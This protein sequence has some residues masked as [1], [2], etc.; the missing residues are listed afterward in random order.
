AS[1][2]A[3]TATIFISR[4]SPKSSRCR[5]AHARK[6]C[7]R[8]CSAMRRGSSTTFAKI[9]TTG[10][11]GMTSGISK[12]VA[13]LLLTSALCPSPS[14]AAP[15]PGVDAATLVV[16]LKRAAPARTAYT[17]V[18]FSG[19]LD[20]PLILRGTLDYLGPRR[21]AKSVEAPYREN[22]KIED[23]EASVQRG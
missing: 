1:T 4:R 9:P 11:T 12:A 2:A 10:S 8:S 7:A 13:T 3:A 19:L 17:E 15:E 23:G 5:G 18:R 6:S 22:T 20:R 14:R 21:L 16:G